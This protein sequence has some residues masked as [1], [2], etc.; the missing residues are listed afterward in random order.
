[1]KFWKFFMVVEKFIKEM[2]MMIKKFVYISWFGDI[3]FGKGYIF[4]ESGVFD[5]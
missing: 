5:K 4:S 3:K 1:M 2:M